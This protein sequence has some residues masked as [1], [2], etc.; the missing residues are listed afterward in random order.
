MSPKYRN[1]KIKTADGVFDS[2]KE[3]ARWVQL[4]CDERAGRITLLR[5]QIPF[6]LLHSQ[7]GPTRTERPVKYIADFVYK[8]DGDLVVEDVKGVRTKEY[9]IKRKLMLKVHGIEIKEV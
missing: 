1:R 6:V 2:A 3:Y 4:K 5:R 8:Q 7:K 9:V